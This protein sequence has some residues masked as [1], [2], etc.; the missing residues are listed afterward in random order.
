MP[1]LRDALNHDLEPHAALHRGGRR[2]ERHARKR[3]RAAGTCRVQRAGGA[4]RRHA[5]FPDTGPKVERTTPAVTR[6]ATITTART[7]RTGARN[8]PPSGEGTRRSRYEH[9]SPTNPPPAKT[10]PAG[11]ETSTHEPDGTQHAERAAGTSEHAANRSGTQPAAR[12]RREEADSTTR[13]RRAA[14]HSGTSHAVSILYGHGGEPIDDVRPCAATRARAWARLSRSR[15]AT[16]GTGPR[17]RRAPGPSPGAAR[18]EPCRRS[19][20]GTLRH[21]ALPRA[22]A[23]GDRRREA[24]PPRERGDLGRVRIAHPRR[25]EPDAHRLGP[26]PRG[27]RAEG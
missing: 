24:P 4:D 11:G 7:R 18:Y 19:C 27:L 13:T 12:Y 20:C 16:A 2:D 10:P 5:P 3:T 8:T 22:H 9:G 23:S 15:H 26:R 6:Q 17:G 21:E 25:G 1:G 14:A